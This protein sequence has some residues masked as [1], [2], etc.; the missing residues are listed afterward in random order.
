MSESG[1]KR[2]DGHGSGAMLKG[3]VQPVVARANWLV[4]L[5]T[6]QGISAAV[7]VKQKDACAAGLVQAK[8]RS[9]KPAGCVRAPAGSF[10]PVARVGVNSTALIA[11]AQKS[12]KF[13]VKNVKPMVL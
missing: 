7:G 1:T 4:C 6:L 3:P 13:A 9:Y 11:T 10:A 2:K 5:A 8:A 12:P